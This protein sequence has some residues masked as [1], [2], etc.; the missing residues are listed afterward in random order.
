MPAM[1]TYRVQLRPEFGFDEAVQVIS[2]LAALGVSHVYCSPYLQAAPGSAHGYDVV[3]HSRVNAELGG[4]AAHQRF[5]EALGA[6]G[7]KQILDIVPNHMAIPGRQ[8]AWWWDVLTHGQ[9]SRYANYFDID[10][11]VPEGTHHAILLPVLGDHYGRVLDRGELTLARV[12]G[13]PVVR[14]YDQEF[15]LD[16]ATIDIEDLE[17]I[18]SPG[19]IGAVLDR[20]H[21][22]LAFWRLADEE[23]DYRRFFDINTLIALRAEDPD[24]FKDTHGLIIK[25]L[26]DGQL[27]GVRI[28]HIDGLRDPA[29]Y[30]ERLRTAAG[31]DK[32]IV[33]EKILE[34]GETLPATWPIAG[35][36]GYDT[37]N[38]I[39]GLFVEPD[40]E[41][42]LDTVYKR[43]VTEVGKYDDVVREG[44]ALAAVQLMGSD[45]TRLSHL[46][47][48]ICARHNRMRDFTRSEL[49][50]V[51]T[52]TL[53]E[54]PVYRSY[55]GAEAQ[56]ITA[57]DRGVISVAIKAA[58]A[59]SNIDPE[60]FAFFEQVLTLEVTGELEG[61]LAMRFQQ[62]S[63]PVMAKGV[64]D[65]TFYRYFRLISRNEVGGDPSVFSTRPDDFHETATSLQRLWPQAMVA[66]T[67]HDTKRSEDARHRINVLSQ[68]PEEWGRAVSRWSRANAHLHRDAD[69]TNVPDPNTEYLIYQ[70]LV[71]AYP[72]SA[73][74]LKDY[75]AKAT[76]EAKQLTTWTEPNESYDVGLTAFVDG[77][78]SNGSFIDDFEEFL[79]TI[80]EAG[81]I[82]SLAATVVK[83]TMPGV[84]DTYQGTE[85]WDTSLVD[86]DNRRP[87]DYKLRETLLS[88]LDKRPALINDEQGVNKLFVTQRLLTLRK[89]NSALGSDASY[90][91]V[92]VTGSQAHHTFAFMRSEDVITLVPRSAD[93]WD[94]T[95]LDFPKGSWVNVF[96]NETW[97]GRAAVADLL[98]Q[99]P[100]AV[101]ERT[102]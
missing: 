89:S 92:N 24:V 85:L 57:A 12:E 96:T 65:T 50:E 45:V 4:E 64:E 26:Q 99:F 21:Y 77:M 46:F 41:A 19:A 39:D 84:P 47:A 95:A 1:S 28:D 75:L 10:W 63:G 34:H 23:L 54:F 86:P 3:D 79:S 100:V 35:T 5:V 70:T 48:D 66:S 20:Q 56:S 31:P 93:T 102:T 98:A 71:G 72:I 73:E 32:W 7:L 22:R 101:F 82:N 9:S 40:G 68:V 43:F 11:Q 37:L 59:S 74:R 2:Y 90:R 61:E 49:R 6:N 33:A 16:P 87:V 97:A 60:L 55:V 67:T 88:Q 80:I 29:Q 38:L 78:L 18:T 36:T 30:L 53:I 27:D 91:G 51:I 83:L 17:A 69:G 42:Q 8:N 25:W 58:A 14:Y 94:D 13:E 15:P 52:S 44:K 81:R 62:L 76:K